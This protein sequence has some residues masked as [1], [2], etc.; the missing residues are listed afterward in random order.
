MIDLLATVVDVVQI[1]SVTTQQ[2]SS[3][4]RGRP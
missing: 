4:Q 1:D 2:D 3:S